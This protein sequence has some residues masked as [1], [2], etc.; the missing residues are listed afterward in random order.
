MRSD[1]KRNLKKKTK[2]GGKFYR[3][4]KQ[5]YNSNQESLQE[6]RIC[7]VITDATAANLFPDNQI[8]GYDFVEKKTLILGAI[9]RDFK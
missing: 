8:L 3:F 1:S 6:Y 4:L 9:A 7:V 2:I 5:T